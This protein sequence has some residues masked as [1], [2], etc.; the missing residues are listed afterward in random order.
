MCFQILHVSPPIC[1]F[2]AWQYVL[3]ARPLSHRS[4]WGQGKS[5]ACIPCFGVLRESCVLPPPPSQPRLGPGTKGR[6]GVLGASV[7]EYVV[8]MSAGGVASAAHLSF[9][10]QV[11][12]AH[13]PS[14][15]PFP[16]PFPDLQGSWLKA[17]PFRGRAP[18]GSATPAVP[19]VVIFECV[20]G[21]H[22]ETFIGREWLSPAF[23]ITSF[24][25][26][27]VPRVPS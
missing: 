23:S 1:G 10:P 6:R 13:A 25:L 14:P 3:E 9:S 20:W 26:L 17:H 15:S 11:P 5:M 27:W 2:W 4:T 8:R 22:R 7:S 24:P 18:P 21:V 16:F 12:K 19:A